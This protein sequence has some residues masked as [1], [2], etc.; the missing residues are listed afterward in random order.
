MKA[1]AR[2]IGLLFIIIF[3]STSYAQEDRPKIGLVLSGG[4]A[5]GIA[6]VG[7][8]K[9]IDSLHI[10]IDY[11]A[12][13]SMGGIIGALYA[14]GFS[15][16]EIEKYVLETDW[17]EMFLDKPPR[18]E[19]P[20]LEKRDDGKFQIE[21]GIEGFT[22]VI[23]SGLIGG[24]NISLKFSELTSAVGSIQDF[25]KL[26]I[27]YKCVAIDLITGNEVVLDRGSLPKAMRA[28]MA[29]PTVFSP[30]EWGDSLLI[31]GGVLNN[32]PADVL[33]EMG[34][35]IIIGVNVGSQLLKREELNSL[36]N[37][38]QQTM[39]LTDY[40][41][42]KENFKLCEVFIQPELEGFTTASFDAASVKVILQRGINAA[43][44]SR[45][46]L[47]EIKNKYAYNSD[48][49][50][51][52]DMLLSSPKVISSIFLAGKSSYTLNYLYQLTGHKPNDTLDVVKLRDKISE[53][54]TSGTFKEIEYDILPLDEES[55]S[56]YFRLIE[57][58]K[59]IIH[60]I[61]IVGNESLHF[62]FLINLL[63]M[64]PGDPFDKKLLSQQI[65]YMSSLGYFQE[66]TYV[67]EPVRDNYIHLTINLK[68]KPLRKLRL[69][70]RYD[71]R[72]KMV[73]ILGLQTT[74]FPVV[75]FRAEAT[76]Q[77]AGLF[78]FDY[79][80]FYPSRTFDLPLYPF[81]RIAYKDVPV[82][83][84]DF[85]SGER[86]AEYNDKSWKF[87]IGFGHI[88]SKTGL[89]SFEYYHEYINIDPNF[90]GFDPILFPS[91]KDNLRI[92]SARLAID[93][94][95]DPIIPRE[96]LFVDAHYDASLK[97]FNSSLEYRFYE[98][99]AKAF[100]TGWK[101]HT[102]G[103]SAYYCNYSG[104]FPT[105]KWPAKGGAQT[106]VGM[107]INQ[108]LGHNYGYIRIDY[109][110]EFKKDIFFKLIANI[111]NYN[112]S[113]YSLSPEFN[114]SLYGLGFGIQLLSIVGPFELIFS[115]GSRSSVLSDQF[116]EVIYFTAGFSF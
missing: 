57:K 89:L 59:P 104:D 102:L 6:H 10:P 78:K 85:V 93:R 76:V 32:F 42:Q 99:D 64:K 113:E 11:I 80:A 18:S 82:D 101:K 108:L 25:N 90:T 69:G 55:V 2:F 26:P 3:S 49:I 63:G 86:M 95:D 70:F 29:I 23:P 74:N 40:A 106:F 36:I 53:M 24:Q 112:L 56:L 45:Q 46:E 87:G 1:K 72:N 4:G 28:T 50:L 114:R 39:V 44:K 97:A 98:I 54:K 7:T 19:I 22:P 83:I 77:F 92:V 12:G 88:I 15:G 33:K 51:E 84:Y 30:V 27:P 91:W 8:L 21:L 66:I 105:Y 13:T 100:A 111:G 17:T 103:L 116:T 94:L 61:S 47:I 48:P 9:L 5:R 96:G 14:C 60:G 71:D 41:K 109:R 81:L 52:E 34:A 65:Q 110:F 79:T 75:G 115:K 37:V 68:E 62:E 35:N 58:Q 38:L 73:G 20:Y 67:I 31:D 16:N 107:K 43:A